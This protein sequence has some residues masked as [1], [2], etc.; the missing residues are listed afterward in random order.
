MSDSVPPTTN[1]LSAQ[2]TS[3]RLDLESGRVPPSTS[4]SQYPSSNLPTTTT[5]LKPPNPPSSFK[6][7]NSNQKPRSLG[8]LDNQNGDE[9]EGL[10]LLNKK[11]RGTSLDSEEGEEDNGSLLLWSFIAM[12]IIGLGNRIFGKLQTIPMHDYPFFNSLLSVFVYVPVCFAY[13]VPMQMGGRFS[14]EQLEIPKYKFFIMGALDS[15]AGVMSTFSLNYIPNASL[16]VLLGQASIPISMLISRL[17]LKAKYSV[18]QYSGALVVILGIIIVLIPEFSPKKPGEKPEEVGENQNFWIFIQVLSIVPSVFSS[19]YK[20][21]AL[22]DVDIDV[23]YLNGWV[24][25]YQL[26]C[27]IPLAI[28]SAWASNLTVAQIPKNMYDGGRCALGY[29]FSFV[30]DTTDELMYHDCSIA[31]FYVTSY[32]VFNLSLNILIVLVLKHGSAAI[33]AMSSTILVPIGNFAF[34]LDFIPGHKPQRPSDLAGLFVIMLGLFIFRY[35]EQFLQN[36]FKS[37]MERSQSKVDMIAE[38]IGA[39]R[40]AAFLALSGPGTGV[41]RPIGEA[42]LANNIALQ[43]RRLN[44]LRSPAQIRGSLLLKLGVKPSPN[45]YGGV[46]PVGRSPALISDRML[47]RMQGQGG[48]AGKGGKGGKGGGMAKGIDRANSMSPRLEVLET[49]QNQRSGGSGSG[50]KSKRGKRGGKNKNRTRGGKKKG[51]EDV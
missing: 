22:G 51:G 4:T 49:Q 25:F 32:L 48:G 29:S 12:T 50:G 33:L 37:K 44:L 2:S 18:S 24:A 45:M 43:K 23:T 31:P 11:G 30:S 41:D 8:W 17:F 10:P 42:Q 19:V 28:P 35:F 9:E 40:S 21:K 27:C 3:M 38:K 34:S 5:S 46:S 15:V 39:S 26:L 14:Q 47:A 6:L 16:V 7:L 13:I 1:P 20:E 36:C